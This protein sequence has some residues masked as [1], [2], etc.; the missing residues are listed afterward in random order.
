MEVRTKKS[1]AFGS[2]EDS[3][4]A[5]KKT[6]L[7]ALAEFYVQQHAGLPSNWRIDIVAIVTDWNGQIAR[8]DLI[9]NAID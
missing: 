7:I 6:K 4:T 8:I 3:I 2:P 5:N 9:T 1:L